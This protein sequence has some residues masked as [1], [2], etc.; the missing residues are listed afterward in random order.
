MLHGLHAMMN[1][2]RALDD[3]SRASVEPT[4]EVHPSV[5]CL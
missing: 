1:A 2:T 5:P 4:E 3:E